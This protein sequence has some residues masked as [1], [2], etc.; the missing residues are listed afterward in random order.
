MIVDARIVDVG[1]ELQHLR[2]Q[3][4]DRVQHGV[5][6]HHAVVLRRDQRD[7]RI[8]QRL[9]RVQH[10]ERG[11]LPG[12]ASSRTPFSAISEAG[13]WACAEDTCALP[14]CNW[15]QACT[16]LARV[17]SRTCSRLS[18]CC[19]RVSLDCRISAYSAP[20]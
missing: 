5:G 7:P 2:R 9:L 10:V 16:T 20:P 13:T 14:A 19:A 6:R 18:R 12:A 8:H 3:P 17:W 15:P 4:A 1:V 11:A